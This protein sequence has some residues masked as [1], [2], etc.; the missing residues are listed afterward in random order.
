M[1]ISSKG[2]KMYDDDYKTATIYINNYCNS[3]IEIIRSY[4]NILIEITENS[5]VDQQVSSALINL[6]NQTLPVIEGIVEFAKKTGN[7]SEKFLLDIDKAD[8]FLY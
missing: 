2:L 6:S 5:I 7:L 1:A 8:S 4:S 3:L